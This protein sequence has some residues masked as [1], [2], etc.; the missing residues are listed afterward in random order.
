MTTCS[1]QAIC[2][3]EVVY[4]S[5][6]YPNMFRPLD[7]GFMTLKNRVIMGSMH[8][9]LEE[10]KNWSRIADF[11]SERAKGGVAL[12]VTGGIAP[13]KEGAVFKCAAA[14]LDQADADNHRIVTDAV[15]ENGG[16]IV[17]Q[18]L[19][20]GRYA[21]SPDCVAPSAIKSPI[22]PFVPV[23]LDN[24]GIATVSYTHLTLPTTPYV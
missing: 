4:M 21:Y 11:Y 2:A 14:M 16:K 7:L 24:E 10:T 1:S 12:I 18:I 17:M 6:K 9:N 15:H 23:S 5:K 3:I 19:H 20:A 13:N 22:S 8:T